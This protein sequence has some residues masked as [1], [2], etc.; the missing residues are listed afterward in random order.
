MKK[1]MNIYGPFYPADLQRMVNHAE[2]FARAVARS[3]SMLSLSRAAGPRAVDD[4]TDAELWLTGRTEEI[5]A[6][7]GD[8]VADWRGGRL[9]ARAAALALRRYL[10]DLHLGFVAFVGGGVAPPCCRPCPPTV[11]VDVAPIA[12]TCASSA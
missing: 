12:R 4:R 9:R 3:A 11:D 5:E 6:Y 7:V 2:R 10:S 1:G 8:V